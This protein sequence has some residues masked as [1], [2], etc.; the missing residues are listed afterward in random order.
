[1]PLDSILRRKERII[2]TLPAVQNPEA[3][4]LLLSELQV[5]GVMDQAVPAGTPV[6]SATVTLSAATA[7]VGET[8]TATVA[9]LPAD[10]TNKTG[11]WITANPN[12]ASVDPATG[13]VT[14]NA[15]GNVRIIWVS[16][17]G[18]YVTAD[19]GFTVTAA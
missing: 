7:V 9:V 8:V 10:A 11:S 16:A 2:K 17:D 1:M 4:K 6:A 19:A 12:R 13:V 14:A 3:R 15:P 5:S 18:S